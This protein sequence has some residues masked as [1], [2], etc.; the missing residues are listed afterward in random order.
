MKKFKYN[1]YIIIETHNC[2]PF[3]YCIVSNKKITLEN[4]VYY[5]EDT[6]GFDETRD[7]IVFIDKPLKLH[8]K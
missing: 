3:V 2:A 6:E 1:Q 7:S 5:F 8:I 4:V